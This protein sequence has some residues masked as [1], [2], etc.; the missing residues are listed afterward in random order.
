[1]ACWP[2]RSRDPGASMSP[3]TKAAPTPAAVVSRRPNGHTGDEPLRSRRF[4]GSQAASMLQFIPALRA[5]ATSL[6]GRADAADD[7][8]QE[9]LARAIAHIGSFEPGTNMCAWLFTILRNVVFSESRKKRRDMAYRAECTQHW[10]THP[11]Q[12]GKVEMLRMRQALMQLPS[13]QRQAIILV[14]A[15]G[16][17]YDE[18]AGVIGCAVGT[19]KSRVSRAR[20]RLVKLLDV[21]ASDRFGPESQELAV[22]A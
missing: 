5:F 4:D 17:S 13:E 19:V 22:V 16:L 3:A 14:G 20:E 7:L 9:T 21:N 1:M 2:T 6:T 8:V 15:S 12:N 18:A 11:E 10:K